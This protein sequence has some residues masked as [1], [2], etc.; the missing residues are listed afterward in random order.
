MDFCT[1]GLMDQQPVLAFYYTAKF[2][3]LWNKD[4]NEKQQENKGDKH[5]VFELV[6]SE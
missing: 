6:F 2:Y 3:F 5:L 4:V 1:H